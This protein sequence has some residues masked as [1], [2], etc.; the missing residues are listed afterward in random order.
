MSVSDYAIGD[1]FVVTIKKNLLTNT[2]NSW[3]NRYEA[4][5]VVAG[6]E[7][8]L[9]ALATACL[10]FERQLHSAAVFFSQI[11]VAT[12]EEDSVPYDPSAFI[13]TPVSTVGLRVEALELENLQTCLSVRRVCAFGRFG[14]LFYRG[15][16]YEDQVSSPSGKS[17]LTVPSAI[18]I[19]IDD[20][21]SDSTLDTYL[22]AAPTAP[23]QICMINKT[24][25]QVRPVLGFI[26]G[27]VALV[28]NDHA[29]YNRT[30]P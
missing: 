26:Q 20:A 4:V 28:P 12:W 17:I 9:L 10:E 25:T 29:W 13:S 5:G 2:E 30:S 18:Q 7:A 8:E 15:C 24:G 27:G 14:H 23:L 19:V 6:A 22:G 21:V 11:S 1:K 16:L 3:V